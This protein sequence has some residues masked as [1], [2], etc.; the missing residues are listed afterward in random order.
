MRKCF[1]IALGALLAGCGGGSVVDY[2]PT[3]DIA[4]QELA[5]SY[6][7]TTRRDISYH[8]RHDYKEAMVANCGLENDSG[9]SVYGDGW[10]VRWNQ[11][12]L[13]VAIPDPESGKSTYDEEDVIRRA[14][15]ILNRS[16]PENKRLAITYTDETFASTIVGPQITY[17]DRQRIRSGEIHAEILPYIGSPGLGWTDGWNKGPRVRS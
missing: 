6:Y 8:G 15:A 3:D 14:V 5:Y 7:G 16:L 17:R 2:A 1:A 9:C 12:P 10:F 13:Y 4:P 11:P